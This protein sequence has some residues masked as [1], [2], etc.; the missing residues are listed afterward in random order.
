MKRPRCRP[1]FVSRPR[2]PGAAADAYS[3]IKP[4]AD[5]WNWQPGEVVYGPP[6]GSSVM[7]RVRLLYAPTPL[8]GGAE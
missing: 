4:S 3:R 7:D 2:A 1:S 6:R 8:D 5:A